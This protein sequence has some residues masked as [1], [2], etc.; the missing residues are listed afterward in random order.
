MAQS[1]PLAPAPVPFSYYP[2]EKNRRKKNQQVDCH[3]DREADA[4]HGEVS[5]T[6]AAGG[7]ITSLPHSIVAVVHFNCSDSLPVAFFA[8]SNRQSSR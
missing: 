4:D 6:G 5:L 7:A 1:P 3:Q 8:G 2:E